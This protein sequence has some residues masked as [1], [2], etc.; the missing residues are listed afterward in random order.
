MHGHY[1][2]QQQ[3][4]TPPTRIELILTLYDALLAK[5]QQGRTLLGR[6]PAEAKRLLAHCQIAVTGM[7]GGIDPA[8]GDIA[9]NFL[10]LYEFMSHCLVQG[11]AEHL[12][13]A[14]D[15]LVT[16][17]DGFQEA[18]AEALDLERGGHLPPLQ[19]PQLVRATA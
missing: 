14:I 10:R 18:R 13:A 4:A 5:M 3:R 8:E 12:D 7:A 6:E 15:V 19:T 1:A 17:R 11:T 16:L 2:Y 9:V